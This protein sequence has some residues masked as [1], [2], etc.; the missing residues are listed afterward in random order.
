MSDAR[1]RDQAPADGDE[2][3]EVDADEVVEGVK[4]LFE[5]PA[6]SPASDT[7]TPPPG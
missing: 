6:E 2:V 5:A 3:D 7:K 4:D 1:D